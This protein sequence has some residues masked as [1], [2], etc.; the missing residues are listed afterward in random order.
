MKNDFFS[1]VIPLHSEE[2]IHNLFKE[3]RLFTNSDNYE[4]LVDDESVSLK[5]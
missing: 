2:N 1:I 3:M 5:V 4:V